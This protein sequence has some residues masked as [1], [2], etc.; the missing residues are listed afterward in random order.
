MEMLTA[1]T[2]EMVR[3]EIWTHLLAYNLLR[4]LMEQAAPLLA[5]QRTRLSF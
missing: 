3:K 5:Y 4:T 2:P 1:K